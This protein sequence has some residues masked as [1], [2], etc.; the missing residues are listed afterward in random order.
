[1]EKSILIDGF[2]AGEISELE[3]MRR[4][5]LAGMTVNEIQTVIDDVKMQDGT[6]YEAQMDL[7][8]TEMSR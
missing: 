1:M 7:I 3:L 2:W 5:L 6:F 4:G 8:R